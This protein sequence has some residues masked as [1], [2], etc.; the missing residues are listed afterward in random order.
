[1]ADRNQLVICKKIKNIKRFEGF[2]YDIFDF[3]EFF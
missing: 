2:S 3:E 1:M